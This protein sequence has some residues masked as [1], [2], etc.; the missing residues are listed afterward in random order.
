MSKVIV[1]ECG[2]VVRGGSDDE[3]VEHARRHVG[4]SH[5]DLVDKVAREE[6]LAMAQED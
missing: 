5:P 1:C 4:D 3:L 2:Y 6:F